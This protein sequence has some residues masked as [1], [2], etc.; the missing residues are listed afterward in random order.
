LSVT[1]REYRTLEEQL[2][3]LDPQSPDRDSVHVVERNETLSQIAAREYGDPAAWR[4]IADHEDNQI[5]NPRRLTPGME[6][7]I[8]ALVN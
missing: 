1:F 6:L 5:D 8:P 7:R 3:E 2:W 4:A